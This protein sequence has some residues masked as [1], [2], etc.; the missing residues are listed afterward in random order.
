MFDSSDH[1]NIGNEIIVLTLDELG[2]F[3]AL[4]PLEEQNEDLFPVLSDRFSGKRTKHVKSTK[5]VPTLNQSIS[6][7]TQL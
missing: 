7:R 5:H 4:E 1:I 3:R 2:G 6:L